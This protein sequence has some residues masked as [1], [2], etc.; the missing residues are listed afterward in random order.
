MIRLSCDSTHFL[1]LAAAFLARDSGNRAILDSRFC[2]AKVQNFR[3][4]RAYKKSDLQLQNMLTLQS[5]I[6]RLA[7][8]QKISDKSVQ[9]AALMAQAGALV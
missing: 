9:A 1:L 7:L 2:A 5:L 8:S 3:N 4:E 6:D